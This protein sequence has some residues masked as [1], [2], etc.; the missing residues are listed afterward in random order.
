[1]VTTENRVLKVRFD[2]KTV[3]FY[4]WDEY[5]VWCRR[6]YYIFQSTKTLKQ[7]SCE[8][9]RGC[10]P[11]LH[12]WLILHMSANRLIIINYITDIFYATQ[13]KTKLLIPTTIPTEIFLPHIIVNTRAFRQL[14]AGSCSVSFNLSRTIVD[15]TQTSLFT[16]IARP[17]T[18]SLS[19][20]QKKVFGHFHSGCF[21]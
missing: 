9:I 10:A 7:E 17:I 19:D 13:L 1:M 18:A 5:R 21:S 14:W 11:I 2:K 16:Y 4:I 12:L 3:T 15:W 6:A 8:R 20:Y